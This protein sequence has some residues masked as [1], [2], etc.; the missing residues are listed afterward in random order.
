[1]FFYELVD[2]FF[3]CGVL[4]KKSEGVF[5]LLALW[6]NGFVVFEKIGE[7]HKF[8]FTM[9]GVFVASGFVLR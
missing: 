7:F 3:I 8:Y 2:N 4:F 1:M 5:P 9:C 6:V